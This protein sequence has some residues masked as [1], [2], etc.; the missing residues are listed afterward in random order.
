MS[1]LHTVP[2]P[3]DYITPLAGPCP[4]ILSILHRQYVRVYLPW[5]RTIPGADLELR[6]GLADTPLVIL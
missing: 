2:V 3:T 5:T 1:L 6:G 4:Y